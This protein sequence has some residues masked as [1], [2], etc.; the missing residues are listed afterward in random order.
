MNIHTVQIAITSGCI[1]ISTSIREPPAF[2]TTLPLISGR[3]ELR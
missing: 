1:H 3:N 2:L